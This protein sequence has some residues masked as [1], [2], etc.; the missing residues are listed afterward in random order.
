MVIR[1]MALW[2]FQED[3]QTLLALQFYTLVS[4]YNFHISFM[5]NQ[6]LM[7]DLNVNFIH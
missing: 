3:Y 2:L 1:C 5:S 6:F 4:C 7:L